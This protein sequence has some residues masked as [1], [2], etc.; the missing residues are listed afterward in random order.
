M[1]FY[2]NHSI[3]FPRSRE[4]KKLLSLVFSFIRAGTPALT[5]HTCPINS[6]GLKPTFITFKEQLADE[7]EDYIKKLI[8]HEFPHVYLQYSG[9]DDNESEANKLADEWGFPEPER[10]IKR[11]TY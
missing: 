4:E 1:F 3:S 9:A 6:K 8:A 7:E 10:Y 11:M 2:G 5:W